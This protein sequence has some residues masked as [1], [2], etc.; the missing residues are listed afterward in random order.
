MLFKITAEECP[1]HKVPQYISSCVTV[2]T[3]AILLA[4]HYDGQ[5]KW[6]LGMCVRQKRTGKLGLLAVPNQ[7]I[8]QSGEQ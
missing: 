7:N 5:P 6:P 1:R 8:Q 2:I 3:H 4:Y